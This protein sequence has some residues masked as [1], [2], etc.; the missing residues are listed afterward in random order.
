MREY[1]H[2]W[3]KKLQELTGF[4]PDFQEKVISTVLALLFFW[5]IKHIVLKLLNKSV[6]DDITKLRWQKSITPVY[7]AILIFTIGRIW[8]LAFHSLANYLGLV[9]AGIAIALKDPLVNV[10]AYT[11]IIGRKPFSVGDRVKVDGISGEKIDVKLFQFSIMEI[12]DWVK[13]DQTTGRIVQIPNGHVFTKPVT[14]Y[15]DGFNFIW[16]ELNVL[17]TFESDWNK[18]KEI[19]QHILDY[20]TKPWSEDAINQIKK[21]D[22]DFLIFNTTTKPTL[23]LNVEASG[24]N[25]TMRYM[26]NPRKRRWCQQ[27]VWEEVL[28]EFANN[29]DIELAYPTTRFY[30]KK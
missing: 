5:F 26:V 28:T 10:F 2:L 9:S 27:I 22:K 30:A 17:I 4:D 16:E 13:G 14:N 7:Y 15:S 6:K 12:G 18:T 8:I 25:F 24:V 23:F 1:L 11:Y 29:K 3:A 20:K 19:L 21:R